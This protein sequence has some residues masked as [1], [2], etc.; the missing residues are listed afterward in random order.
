MPKKLLIIEDDLDIQAVLYYIFVEEGYEVELSENGDAAGDMAEP[1]PDLILMD[2]QLKGALK[3][4]DAVCLLLKS[5]AATHDLPVILLSAECDLNLICKA[6][7]AD[8][9]LCKPFD[10]ARL[11]GLVAELIGKAAA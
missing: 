4:G 11:T 2:V 8:G 1:F 3:N 7:G 6:C 9:F 5:V 10:V